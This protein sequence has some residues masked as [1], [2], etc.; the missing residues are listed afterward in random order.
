MEIFILLLAALLALLLHDLLDA[1]G[2]AVDAEAD[3]HA[4]ARVAEHAL[5]VVHA[6]AMVVED[7]EATPIAL[8]GARHAAL[9]LEHRRDDRGVERGDLAAVELDGDLRRAPRVVPVV[10][11]DAL[12]LST[13]KRG[14]R[15]SKHHTHKG[16]PPKVAPL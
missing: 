9:D 16:Q 15:S 8:H 1:L 3:V 5:H 4:G 11:G 2:P 14:K 10:G 13:T 7:L 6:L 12:I